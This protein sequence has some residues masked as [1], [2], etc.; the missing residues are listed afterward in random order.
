MPELRTATGAIYYEVLD[1]ASRNPAPTLTLLHNFMSSGRAA[2]GPLLPE[3]SESYRIILPDLPGHGR[4]A[5]YPPAYD[6]R[7]IARQI[8]ALMAAEGARDGHLAGCSS[9]GMIA[10]QLV[11][12][13][14]ARPATLTLVST[15]YSVNPRTT[16]NH[17]ALRT[18]D[19]D[20]SE[21]WLQATARLHDPYHYDGYYH[22]ELLPAFRR[23]SPATA[24]DLPLDALT[25]FRMPVCVIHGS[26]DEFFPTYI[27]EEMAAAAPLGELH[28]VPGQKHALLFRQPWRVA[29]IMI[30]FLAKHDP[31]TAIR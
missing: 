10:Q 13:R 29:R 5:G 7:E 8:A 17:T 15:T 20:A 26:E 1:A 6:H 30:E 11:Y 23:L 16:D 9:G 27:A 4:S 25:A 22:S 31:S 12:M 19:F 21:N 14:L 18:E 3:L 24:I 28:I 2:W